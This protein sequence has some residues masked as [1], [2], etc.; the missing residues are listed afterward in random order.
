MRY[1][2]ANIQRQLQGILEPRPAVAAIA[3]STDTE[4]YVVLT[5]APLRAVRLFRRASKPLWETRVYVAEPPPKARL[6]AKAHYAV[7]DVNRV[8]ALRRSE[9]LVGWL[10]AG[11]FEAGVSREILGAIG[12]SIDR[13]ADAFRAGEVS[14]AIAAL[15]EAIGIASRLDA[16]QSFLRLYQEAFLMRGLA[17]ERID[18]ARG[19]Q[20]YRDFIDRCAGLAP[21]HP[22]TLRAVAWAREAVERLVPIPGEGRARRRQR[23]AREGN[24]G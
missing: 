10:E 6:Q 17:L 16:T 2:A 9:R 18:P 5:L 7:F 11:V 14:V 20:A 8:E 21:Y 22:E 24:G 15:D 4:H 1:P 19:K 12:P 23:E 13:A 3:V